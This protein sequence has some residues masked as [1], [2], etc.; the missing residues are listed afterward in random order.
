MIKNELKNILSGKNLV[1]NGELIQTIAIHLRR[2]KKT[3]SLASTKEYSKKQE[4]KE[5]ITYIN[6]NN[7]DSVVFIS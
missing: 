7:L 2:S 4:T 1:S 3:S 6:Q 5:L